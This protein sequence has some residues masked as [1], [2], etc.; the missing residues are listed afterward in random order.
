MI[1]RL[2]QEKKDTKTKLRREAEHVEWEKL[3]QMAKAQKEKADA[4][5]QQARLEEHRKYESGTSATTDKYGSEEEREE[6]EREQDQREQQFYR[7]QRRRQMKKLMRKAVGVFRTLSRS[8]HV[9]AQVLFAKCLD[10]GHGVRK[11]AARALELLLALADQGSA[12]AAFQV[13][14]HK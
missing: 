2:F 4:L 13:D 11:D 5:Q 10:A 1:S 3:F 9:G 7:A 8:G 12:D 14:E 6:E